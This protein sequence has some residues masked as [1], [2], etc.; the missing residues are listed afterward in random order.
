MK[1]DSLGQAFGRL[2]R[3]ENTT[4]VSLH[5]LRH[6]SASVLIAAGRDARTVAGRLGHADASTTLRVYAHMVEGRDREA[7]DLL[8]QLMSTG[9]PAALEVADPL[10]RQNDR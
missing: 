3:A 2:C 10:A 8:G 7:A 1:P 4:G 5:T 9:Q 6:L